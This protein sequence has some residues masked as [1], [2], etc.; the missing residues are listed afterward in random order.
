MV[1]NMKDVF[2]DV[3]KVL[4]EL[5]NNSELFDKILQSNEAYNALNKSRKVLISL[6]DTRCCTIEQI[7]YCFYSNNQ[8][9]AYS[10]L[11]RLK[12]QGLLYTER[13]PFANA[14][15]LTNKGIDAA[16]AESDFFQSDKDNITTPIENKSIPSVIAHR[17]GI[18]TIYYSLLKNFGFKNF[19]WYPESDYIVSYEEDAKIKADAQ[20][21]IHGTQYIVEQDIETVSKTRLENKLNNYG[22]VLTNAIKKSPEYLLN[23]IFFSVNMMNDKPSKYYDTLPHLNPIKKKIQEMKRDL[24][25]DD[26]SYNLTMKLYEMD[27]ADVRKMLK[28][29]EN[30][31]KLMHEGKI[32]KGK[33]SLHKLERD[34]DIINKYLA[35]NEDV[36][37]LT[38]F[39]NNINA[40]ETYKKVIERYEKTKEKI[41]E[42]YIELK[43]NNRIRQIKYIIINDVGL[44]QIDSKNQIALRNAINGEEKLRVYG[45][46]ELL[47]SGLDIY[48]NSQKNSILFIE[49][50]ATLKRS[51]L[52]TVTQIMQKIIKR[53]TRNLKRIKITNSSFERIPFSN[54]Y[55]TAKRVIKVLSKES[56][57]QINQYIII[58]DMSW[59][60]CG[61]YVRALEM[62][63]NLSKLEYPRA[64][65]IVDAETQAR[66][67]CDA[68]VKNN[69]NTNRFIFI[70]KE[71]VL[72]FSQKEE[73]SLNES[74]DIELT[75]KFYFI[76]NNTKMLLY[77]NEYEKYIYGEKNKSVV[78][79]NSNNGQ[80]ATIKESNSNYKNNWI[81]FEKNQTIIGDK[82]IKNVEENFLTE[83]VSNTKFALE[84]INNAK[85]SST[86][87]PT[88]N[89]EFILGNIYDET[90]IK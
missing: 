89:N 42:R 83:T 32:K 22:I 26:A 36:D 87:A 69:G 82:N 28:D 53:E 47:K 6:L 33:Y 38:R 59:G 41:I 78:L 60:N 29:I 64:V 90:I 66:E 48:I 3:F 13:Y 35:K 8:Y 37:K 77:S 65:L 39:N 76:I 27:D 17:V 72:P 50:Q 31:I 62:A 61:G 81:P 44:K 40:F 12:N 74:T 84:N 80:A 75:K 18:S 4:E 67:I 23:P 46:Y 88:S 49:E 56:D 2:N 25:Y 10:L 24:V 70:N 43:I 52:D 34:K 51:H 16:L 58:D 68:V 86:D 9:S 5:E 21:K 19:K 63:K 73:L 71:D 14:Y 7:A 15:F 1:I 85:V 57:N 20:F 54:D 30:K 79:K 55:V 45:T 11:N